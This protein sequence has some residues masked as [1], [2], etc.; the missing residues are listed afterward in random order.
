MCLSSTQKKNHVLERIGLS[1]FNPAAAS[2]GQDQA[3]DMSLPRFAS[4]SQVVVIVV[5]GTSLVPAWFQRGSSLVPAWFQL[6]SSLAPA[7]FQPSSTG[8]QLFQA[9]FQLGFI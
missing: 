8:F 2:G 9:E 4:M 5:V 7:W 3:I 6:G 1:G